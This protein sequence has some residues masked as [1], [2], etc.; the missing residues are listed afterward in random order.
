MIF[1]ISKP[2]IRNYISKNL[3]LTAKNIGI[4]FIATSVVNLINFLYNIVMG[5]MLGPSEY[6]VLVSITSL[7]YISGTIGATVQTTL[8]KNSSSY[9][10]NDDLNKVRILFYLITKRLFI[11]TVIIF[12][13]ILIFINQITAFLKL[14]SIYPLIFLGIMI[15]VSSLVAI[16]GGVLQGIQNFKSLG[17]ISILVVLLKLGLG[18][19]LVYV[20]FKS[21]GAI[22]G[23]MLATLFSYFFI[24]IP[25]RK[26]LWKKDNKAI[27]DK[28]NLKK[29]YKNISLI[30]ISTILISIL[31][32]M[33]I[34]L[35]KHFFTSYETGQYSAAAQIGRIIL[36]FP[37]AISIVIFPR[38]SEKF[39][40]KESVR[41][42][43]IKSLAIILAVSVVFLIFYY[44]F[45]KLVIGIIYGKQYLLASTL[46]FK[47]GIFMTLISMINLQIFYFIAIDKFWYLISLLII[48]ILQIS[49]I[50]IYHMNLDIVIWILVFV[51]F[52]FF[53][54]NSILMFLNI[55][56]AD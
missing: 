10:A 18:V 12:I 24:L 31:A 37:G 36:F 6:G 48:V 16:G 46:V 42:T 33:D 23:L 13:I 29:F 17:I 49:L 39:T 34:V 22:F 55:K 9:L 14:N 56:K 38:L 3:N 25:L 45:P 44:F 41:N 19:I 50:W 8:A 11:I 30:L 21:G 15:V 35:V 28:I 2:K 1:R 51:S 26:I 43:V 4:M 32:Y 52:I 7:L 5:R 47:Y 27:D 40:K 20:G 53:L 54:V